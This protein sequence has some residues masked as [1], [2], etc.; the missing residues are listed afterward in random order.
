V[1]P[2]GASGWTVIA[3]SG[4]SKEQDGTGLD[5]SF[6]NAWNIAVDQAGYLY[7]VDSYA[8]LRRVRHTGGSLTD[9]TTWVVETLVHSASAPVDGSAGTGRVYKLTGVCCASDGTLYLTEE[10]DIRRLDR[11]R[12]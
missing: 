3:G 2:L 7:V 12:N 10:N 9:P 1:R 5:A 4:T 11:T 6:Q 8:S